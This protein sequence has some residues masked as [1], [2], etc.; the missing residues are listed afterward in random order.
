MGGLYSQLVIRILRIRP[1]EPLGGKSFQFAA[2]KGAF[3][4]LKIASYGLAQNYESQVMR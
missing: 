1:G 3:V 2:Q 4:Y